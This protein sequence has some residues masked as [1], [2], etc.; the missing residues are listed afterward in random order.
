MWVVRRVS[1]RRYNKDHRR[2]GEYILEYNK[3]SIDILVED[4]RSRNAAGV[5]M[6]DIRQRNC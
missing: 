3:E 6:T 1:L 4:G 2:K 5:D